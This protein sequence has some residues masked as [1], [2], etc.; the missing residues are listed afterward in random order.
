MRAVRTGLSGNLRLGVIPTALPMVADLTGPFTARHPGVKVTILSRTS[1]EILTQIEVAG[2]G[3]RDHLSGQRTLGPGARRCRLYTEFYRFL[4]APGTPL[5][6]RS[7]VTWA[8]AA[9]Q[10][11]CLLTGDMQN[12]RIVNQHLAEV[13]VQIAPAIESNSTIALVSACDDRAL[14]LGGADAAGAAVCRSRAAGRHS[15]RRSPRPSIWS[16]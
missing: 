15:H 1:A 8:E 12:R 6:G 7:S 3:G 14:G 13:G 16:A 5:A 2:S 11:L 9:E 10:P 4:C